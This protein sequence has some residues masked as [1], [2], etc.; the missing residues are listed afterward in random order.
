MR[1]RLIIGLLIS[2]LA[3]CNAGAQVNSYQFSQLD[4][5]AGLSHN[6]V[7]CI[8][9]DAKGFM[10]FGTMSGLN[11]YDGY[12]FKIFKHGIHD[13]LSLTDD[14]VIRISEVPGN[15]LFI[16]TSN[17]NNIYDP[18]C[19]KFINANT[20]LQRISLPV[21]G[22]ITTLKA[23]NNF[24]FVYADVLYKLDAANKI[25]TT[26]R[27][28]KN[29]ASA[30]DA[31]PIADAKADSENNLFIIHRNGILEKL[32]VNTNAVIFRTGV[33]QK[34]R[35][36]VYY[37]FSMFADA[38]NDV[39]VYTTVSPFG[40]LYYNAFTNEVKHL[41]KETGILNSD[42]VAGVIQDDK[43]LIWIATDHGGINVID[44]STFNVNIITNKEDDSKSLAENSV[45]AIYKDDLGII[46]IG[47][48]KKGISYYAESSVKFQLFKHR[49][50][51]P[52]SLQYD[53]VNKF[54]E[55]AQGNIWIGT[56]GGG[57]IYFNRH[58][59]K[60]TQY[61]HEPDNSNS[62]SNDV[63]VSLWIDRD[64]NLWIGS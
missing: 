23:G 38:Q 30:I 20:Y 9:K 47:T 14:D 36:S 34:E 28:E 56:N 57:L 13:S 3:V 27:H 10:W 18:L 61:K 4:I 25:I 32:D 55:D 11:R 59:N 21:S 41:S 39:W 48:Y 64:Q 53:D 22:I 40:I 7:N 19:E 44:K 37:S 1:R 16:Q 29:S 17:G 31:E 42:L 63:I 46:W 49:P 33:I 8:Y 51:D 12:T 58:T 35:K 45:P 6:Q 15:K 2:F 26:I 50:S 54:A 60:F 62:I 5:S 52:F 24:W 43:G